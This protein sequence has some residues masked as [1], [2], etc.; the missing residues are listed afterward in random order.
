MLEDPAASFGDAPRIPIMSSLHTKLLNIAR[1]RYDAEFDKLYTEFLKLRER[2]FIVQMD[3]LETVVEHY[4]SSYF[5]GSNMEYDVKTDGV[6]LGIQVKITLKNGE[7]RKYHVK[8]HS[9]GRLSSNSSAAKPVNPQDLIVQ[10][11]LERLGFGCEAHFLQRSLKDV[12]I[13]TLDAGHGG[14][15]NVFEKA[16][17]PLEE[18]G[19]EAY[20]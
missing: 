6:Q 5:P 4:F 16:T 13:A 18:A 15:F 12:Y 10:K 2:V 11:V 9:S 1:K 20:G 14:S 19:D 8:T 3:R 7:K 17:G